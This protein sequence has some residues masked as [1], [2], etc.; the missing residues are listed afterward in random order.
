[1]TS[2]KKEARRLK[3][4]VVDERLFCEAARANE[5]Q[6][7]KLRSKRKLG[8]ENIH[9]IQVGPTSPVLKLRSKR[10][11][12]LEKYMCIFMRSRFAQKVRC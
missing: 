3:A 4:S 5:S 2:A 6:V 12:G 9:E 7:L 1:M 8:F 11:L 10:K